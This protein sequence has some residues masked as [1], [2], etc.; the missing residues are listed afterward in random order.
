[1]ET[2]AALMGCDDIWAEKHLQLSAV[3]NFKQNHFFVCQELCFNLTNQMISD[4]FS[5]KADLS[6]SFFLLIAVA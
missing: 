3:K 6:N 2:W 4:G 5:T 1:M